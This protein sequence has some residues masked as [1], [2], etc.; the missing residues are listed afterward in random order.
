MLVVT[1]Y[2]Q[3]TIPKSILKITK[4]VF[5]RTSTSGNI[6][7]DCHIYKNA[8]FGPTVFGKWVLRRLYRPKRG[9]NRNMDENTRLQVHI[10]QRLLKATPRL[11]M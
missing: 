8:K 5:L 9:T 1:A 4:T 2:I 3:Y 10:L 7:F 6:Y 11:V